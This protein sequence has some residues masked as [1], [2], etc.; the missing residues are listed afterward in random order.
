[1]TSIEIA[2]AWLSAF[3][4]HDVDALVALY[5]ED[6]T[7]TS[8]KIRAL[9]AST[10]SGTGDKL[11]GKA[12]LA[13]WWRAANARLPGLR[14]EATA[15]VADAE[16]AIIEYVRHAPGEPPMPVAEAFDVRDGT[17]V[18]SRVYHG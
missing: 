3:N 11:V 8:P 2:R 6:A 4:A 14:Y 10:G 15:I 12:A 9:H 5:A 13:A 1:M 16:R 17:I 7:H 18:A